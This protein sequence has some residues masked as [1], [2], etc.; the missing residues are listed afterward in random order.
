MTNRVTLKQLAL[1][2]TALAAVCGLAACGNDDDKINVNPENPIAGYWLCADEDYDENLYLAFEDDGSGVYL[3]EERTRPGLYTERVEFSYR[4]KSDNCY[5]LLTDGESTT[6]TIDGD[7]LKM[8]GDRYERCPKRALPTVEWFPGGESG[9]G[10]S[11][12][13]NDHN[14]DTTTSRDVFSNTTWRLTS[15]KGWDA[16][17]I[18]E[19]KGE[20]LAFGA[21][22]SV[23]EKYVEGGEGKGSY[24]LSGDD[25]IQF[26]GIA[27]AKS[28]GSRFRY[29]I[30]SSTLRLEEYIGGE[31][32]YIFTR[33]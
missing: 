32:T 10:N 25:V 1:S 31:S 16:P 8:D 3:E 15:I 7:V 28:F 26:D 30:S 19:W 23:T 21:N 14:D 9:G 4:I 22:G 33:Q 2:L 5:E 6:A 20:V 18:D 24:T 13:G 17:A 11:G 12:S 27:W 29:T